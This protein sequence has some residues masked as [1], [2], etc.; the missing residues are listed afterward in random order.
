M[1]DGAHA[2]VLLWVFLTL[3]RAFSF[4]TKSCQA[5]LNVTIFLF[6]P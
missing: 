6:E 5:Q 2:A 3:A 1:A 4:W